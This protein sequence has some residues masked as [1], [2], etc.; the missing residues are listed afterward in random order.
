[1]SFFTNARDKFLKAFSGFLA[2]LSQKCED[3]LIAFYNLSKVIAN[4][5]KAHSFCE[6]IIIASSQGSFRNSLHHSATS[7][8]I[9][10]VPL[11]NNTLRQID[12]MAED[13]KA[14]LC[15]LLIAP[16][17]FLYML[18]NQHFRAI[19]LHCWHMFGF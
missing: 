13:I 6:E 12:E 14:Y 11:S 5:R 19:R 1:M 2:F 7:S 18:M 8:V 4:T 9:E 16:L 3:G 17:N 10:N 15:K